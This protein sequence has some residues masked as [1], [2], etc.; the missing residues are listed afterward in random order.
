M[1]LTVVVSKTE[2]IEYKYQG[3]SEQDYLVTLIKFDIQIPV[4]C[5]GIRLNQEKKI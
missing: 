4:Q 1:L 3:V 5:L 2:I